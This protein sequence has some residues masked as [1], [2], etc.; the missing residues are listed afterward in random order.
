MA[1]LTT[2]KCRIL[3]FFFSCIVTCISP[4]FASE[5][6]KIGRVEA[7]DPILSTQLRN[8]LVIQAAKALDI[9]ISFMDFP[10]SRSL[11]LVSKGVLD[12]EIGRHNIIETLFPTLVRVNEAIGYLD[13]WVWVPEEK[14]CVTS[15]EALR[16][17]KPVGTRGILFYDQL[18]YPHSKVGYEKVNSMPQLFVMLL[19]NHADYTVHSKQLIQRLSKG[20]QMKLKSCLDTPLFTLDFYLYLHPSKQH[21][22]IPLEVALRKIKYGY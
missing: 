7:L 2:T 12:A 14:Q 21:F 16:M 6:L 17:L 15:R 4:V 5:S 13:Y 19:K 1:I 20:K 3:A 11:K 10:A 9:E 8:H 18:V 22:K